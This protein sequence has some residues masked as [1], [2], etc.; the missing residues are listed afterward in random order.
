MR[1][2]KRFHL[3]F[4][5]FFFPG[6]RNS[7]RKLS[8]S[9]FS[10][11]LP[12]FFL[13]LPGV[14]P[15]I[16]SA[17]TQGFLP[18]IFPGIPLSIPFAFSNVASSRIFFKEFYLHSAN[19]SGFPSGSTSGILLSTAY[20]I[21]PGTPSRILLGVPP[22]IPYI[23]ICESV[24]GVS[25]GILSKISSSIPPEVSPG[26]SSEVSVAVPPDVFR[27]YVRN[28]CGIAALSFIRDSSTN[29]DILVFDC[30]V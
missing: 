20:I 27:D 11:F 5:K 2:Q 12:K 17:V 19:L 3:G 24:A 1:F 22:R 25:S 18:G 9:I 29:T 28:S 30:A 16:S 21:L 4:L 8:S 6:F 15:E 26:I 13:I 14:P 10:E 23:V 7:F